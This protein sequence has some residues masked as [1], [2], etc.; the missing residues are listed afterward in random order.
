MAFHK[1]IY[2]IL[3]EFP[4]IADFMNNSNVKINEARFLS[5]Y[6]SDSKADARRALVNKQLINCR[7]FLNRANVVV[8]F[9]LNNFGRN[10]II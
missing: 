10:K 9:N 8:C 1:N 7:N 3:S 4:Y 6:I 5:I 2:S